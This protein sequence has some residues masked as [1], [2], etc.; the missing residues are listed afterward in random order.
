MTRKLAQDEIMFGLVEGKQ[1]RVIGISTIIQTNTVATFIGYN[2][3]YAGWIQADF[4]ETYSRPLYSILG[5]SRMSYE[6][7]GI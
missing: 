1:Y 5:G 3:D 4:K 2:I 7:H 6:F